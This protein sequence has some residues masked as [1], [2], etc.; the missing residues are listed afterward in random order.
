MAKE[1]VPLWQS[2][3]DGG[4]FFMRIYEKAAPV[5]WEPPSVLIQ[6]FYDR[7]FFILIL[8]CIY[9]QSDQCHERSGEKYCSKGNKLQ[10]SEETC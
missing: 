8:C 2:G 3:G 5:L 1:G 10:I 9:K 7:L 4:V 6:T